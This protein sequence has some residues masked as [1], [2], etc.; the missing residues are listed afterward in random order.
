MDNPRPDPSPA[1]APVRE[2]GPAG[3]LASIKAGY[4]V[5]YAIDGAILPFLSVFFAR[6]HGLSP[7]QIGSIVAAAGAMA[8]L[9]PFL[10][11]VLADS[12]IRAGRLLM[13]LLGMSGV[14]LATFPIMD[15]YW[16]VLALYAAFSL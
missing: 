16:S 15:G 11:S 3:S 14:L 12:R 1:S 13:L 10:V 9:T 4:G 2:P 7:S 6:E 8:V 5:V